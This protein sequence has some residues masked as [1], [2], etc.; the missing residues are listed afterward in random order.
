MR[1]C[2][3]TL[4]A[5]WA[6]SS[7]PALAERLAITASIAN[8][9]SGPGSSYDILWSVQKYY[10]FEVIKK[11]GAWY[12]F[13]DFEDDSGWVHDSLAGK[14]Q[15]VI[16]AKPNCNV[17]TGAGTENEIVFSVGIGVPFKVLEQKN[18]W[19]RVLHADGDQGWIHDSLV[20]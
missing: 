19:L 9:R 3:L 8:I 20:W 14:L 7:Q 4:L 16:T 18:N 5:F 2:T 13:R 12:Q 15:T 10:P 11:E 1:F 17:R 6:V